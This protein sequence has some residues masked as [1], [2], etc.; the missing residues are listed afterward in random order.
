MIFGDSDVAVS[1][2][3]SHSDRSMRLGGTLLHRA[4]DQIIARGRIL[5]AQ[6]LE[7]A[8]DDIVYEAG[9]F[10]VAGTDRSLGLYECA[11]IAPLAATEEISQRLH[12][13]PTGAAACEVEI[14]PE[15]G[16]LRLVRYVTIDDV[17]RIINPMIVEGQVHGGIAQSV[18]QAL[19]ET[20]IYG[21]DAAQLLTGSFLDYTMPR[22]DDLPSFRT[23]TNTT[24]AESNPL[25]IKGAGEC[26]TT[27]ATA[28]IINAIADA[29]AAY[30]VRHLEMP[31]TAERIWRAI[32]ASQLA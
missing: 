31:A 7:A 10:A 29:L 9:R 16:A 26:G 19:M 2:G 14:D 25:G 12:A 6:A 21:K 20:C 4:S 5:A 23:E 30:G 15:T 17:G 24:L 11:A 18:G 8:A 32:Q 1:G 22:A 27:P 13:H 28:A 3:G